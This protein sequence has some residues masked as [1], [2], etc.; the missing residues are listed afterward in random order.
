MNSVTVTGGSRKDSSTL[1]ASVL[2]LISDRARAILAIEAEAK[3][4]KARQLDLCREQWV[5]HQRLEALGEAERLLWE[6]R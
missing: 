6:R 4:L 5:I 3:L 1:G 2:S